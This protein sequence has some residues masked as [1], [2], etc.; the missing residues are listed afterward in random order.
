MANAVQTSF[1]HTYA[2]KELITEIFWQP[3]EGSDDVFSNY[4]VMNVRDKKNLYIPGT[5]QKI[6]KE[7]SSCG[8]SASGNLTI[9]DRTISTEKVKVNLQQ[10]E[11]AWDDTIFA[12]SL[13]TGT[14]IDDLRGTVVET[15][16]RRK[17]LE[18]I[19]VDI[20]RMCWFGQDGAQADYGPFDGWLELALSSSGDLGQ[21]LDMSAN[22]SIETASDNDTLVSDGS[23]TAFRLLWE[24]QSKTLRSVPKKDKRWFV[25]ATIMDNYLTTL[26]DTQNEK[27]QTTL[28]DGTEIVKFRG[29]LLVEVLGW[30]TQ[31]SDS[32]NPQKTPIGNNL[33]VYT[34]PENL[35]VGSD[36]SDPDANLK[37]FHS[38]ETETLKTIAKLKLGAQILHPE[39]MSIGK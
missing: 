23:I 31:L 28:E 29:Q 7:Y 13:R 5:L 35:I 38:E 19:R 18:A 14:D 27:G 16:I 2:G 32:D 8:F 34:T 36:I 20:A 21:V 4:N 9:S 12:E 26:E 39:L 17:T 24:G 6:L 10:C 22:G 15:I 37:M 30:D 33:I 11:D 3:Q 1:T 25:T